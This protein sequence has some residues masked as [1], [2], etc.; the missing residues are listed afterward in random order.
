VSKQLN[1]DLEEEAE[2]VNQ[3]HLGFFLW[4]YP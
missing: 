4:S 1:R 2:T 3:I